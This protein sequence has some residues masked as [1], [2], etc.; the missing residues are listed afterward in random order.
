MA[1]GPE[2]RFVT[3][4]GIR[5]HLADWGGHGPILLLVHG[6]TG[7]CRIWDAIAPRLTGRFHPVAFDLRGRGDSDKPER[8]YSI[9]AHAADVVG[10]LDALGIERAPVVG[11]S[12]GGR[13][14]IWVAAHYAHRISHLISI[15]G[16]APAS[17][18][19]GEGLRLSHGRV[20]HTY[21]SVEAYLEAMRTMPYWDTWTAEMESYYRFDLLPNP[22]GTV[23]HKI[24]PSTV[25]EEMASLPSLEEQSALYWKVSCPMLLL[26]ACEGVLVKD[27]PFLPHSSADL[28]RQRV[29]SFRY[30]PFEH[31]SHKTILFSGA[32]K[33]GREIAAFLGDLP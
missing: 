30:V 26:H 17:P 16:G 9:A 4:N 28:M 15:D 32:E 33:V 20:D 12:I 2:S 21:A 10:V 19:S 1:T 5:L 22:D 11:H 3:V 29:K 14:G 27:K 7:S 13:I 25:A 31:H 6:V 24:S 8:G 18:E 23:R